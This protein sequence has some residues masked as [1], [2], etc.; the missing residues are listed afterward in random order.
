MAME[1][2]LERIEEIQYQ[3]LNR[4]QSIFGLPGRPTPHATSHGFGLFHQHTPQTATQQASVSASPVTPTLPPDARRA[5][6]AAPESFLSQ[7]EIE[8]IES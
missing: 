4:L 8:N 1:K 7:G 3:I 2:K 6:I 5:I